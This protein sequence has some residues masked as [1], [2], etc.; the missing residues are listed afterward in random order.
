M[1]TLTIRCLFILLLFGW[2]TAS[3]QN[4][5]HVVL[6]T[7]D[8]LR[9]EFYQDPSW[10]MVNLSIMAKEGVYAEGVNSVFPS[11]TLPAHT[12]LVTGVTPARHG[13]YYNSPFIPDRSSDE[14]YWYYSA[15]KAPTLWQAVETAGMQTAS[16][17]WPVA[18]GS[19][20]TYNVPVIKKKG[21]TQLAVTIPHITPPQLFEKIEAEA[22]GKLTN[23]DFSIVDDYLVQDQTMARI[24]AYLIRTFKPNFITIHLTA[25][26]HY[27]HKEGRDGNMVRRAVSGVDRDLRTIIESIERAGIKDSTA[28][29]V[30]GDHG[31]VNTKTSIAP[32]VW[33]SKVGLITDIKTGAW[34][35]QF[36]SAGGSAF[37]HLK[38]AADKVTLN[39]VKETISALPDSVKSLFKVIDVAEFK[40]SGGDPNAV[41]ALGATPGISFS[42][43]LTGEVFQPAGGST[44]G[45]L[46][47]FKEI[48]TGFVA[49]GRGIKKAAVVKQMNLTD[50]APLVARLLGIKFLDVENKLAETIME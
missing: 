49:Y 36:K 48:Q 43:S 17:N 27:Q 15:I 47:D 30:T 13:I 40:L 12:T 1:N 46:P 6:I 38:D 7:I 10:G 21:V 44:H 33:L 26:D 2:Q 14:W 35:A 3:T 4:V 39:K 32:N 34:K 24:G 11:S 23:T 20:I 22:T 37:L 28:V 31:H 42:G 41:L 5:K 50:I 8:G 18:V 9:P 16:V 25:V 19:P 29:I 45:H